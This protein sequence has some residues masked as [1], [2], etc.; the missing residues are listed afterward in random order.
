MTGTRL[1]RS[2]R[3]RVLLGVCGGLARTLGV[4]AALVRLAFAALVL[5]GGSGLVVYGALALLLPAPAEPPRPWRG[6]RQEA[7]GIAA[8]M[9]AAS[10][11]LA[12]RDLLIPLH[13]LVPAALLAGGVALVWRQVVAGRAGGERPALR[14][15]VRLGGG[16]ALVGFGA[17]L[18]LSASGDLAQVSS[19]LVAGAIVATGLGLLV[20]PRLAR[21]RADAEAERRERIRTEERAHVAARLH[22]SV[23]QTL[24]LIQRVDDPRRAQ[25]LARR[26]E[27]ELRAWLYGGEEPGEPATLA[28]ALRAAAA[29]VEEHYGVAVELVQPSDAPLDDA[30]EALAAAAREAMTNAGR[31]AGVESISVLARVADGEASVFVRDRGAGFDPAAVAEDRRGLRESITGRMARAGGRATVVSAPGDGT[32]VELLLPRRSSTA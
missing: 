15:I 9:A 10:V 23:L 30:L 18:F 19:A 3:D 16:L 22:D 27:R 12:V 6:R 8:L 1:E 20:G 25:S 28:T 29:D 2:A 24:A 7:I 31:H 26:Q 11:G 14:E 17:V 32:E 4:D 21:A 5:L 13:V